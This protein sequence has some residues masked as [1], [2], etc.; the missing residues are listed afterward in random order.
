MKRKRIG[1]QTARFQRATA[2]SPP[3]DRYMLRLY[4]AGMNPRSSEAIRT[5]TEICEANLENRYDLDIIDLYKHPALAKQ[6][7]IIA[8]PTLVK[9]S[10][11][12]LRRIIGSMADRQRVLLSLNLT[13]A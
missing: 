6:Q 12:P 7:Q 2:A 1:R 13:V 3:L 10:P 4:V 5:V 11:L 8:A 9:E